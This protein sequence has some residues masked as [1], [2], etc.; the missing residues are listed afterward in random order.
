MVSRKECEREQFCVTY[1]EDDMKVTSDNI[2]VSPTKIRTGN[3]PNRR[4]KYWRWS[5]LFYTTTN[6]LG[7]CY[8]FLF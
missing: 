5:I 7:L 2:H 4:Q 6:Q 3:F 8:L 1:I